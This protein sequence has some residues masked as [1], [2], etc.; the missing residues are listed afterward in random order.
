[1]LSPNTLLNKA[2][3]R[4]DGLHLGGATWNVYAA[5]DQTEGASVLV[6]EHQ[7]EPMAFPEHEGLLKTAD[8]FLMNGRRYDVTEP[9][10]PGPAKE[11][12]VG[13]TWDEF[14]V[15]L[16]A[17]NTIAA[18]GRNRCV[19]CPKT[20]VKASG[21]RKLLAVERA[22]T[23]ADMDA[24]H[25]P[26]EGIW[27]DLDHISQ[28]AIYTAWDEKSIA[29]LDLPLNEASDI[30]SVAAL[31][32][33]AITGTTPPSAFER[34]VVGM[35][36][37]DPLVA[38]QGLRPDLGDEGGSHLL[39]CLELLRLQRFQTFEDAIMNLPTLTFTSP[40]A[41][42]E[43]E[44][45]VL[46]LSHVVDEAPVHAPVPVIDV[47]GT[48]P[49][50]Q[51]S[52]IADVSSVASPP[53]SFEPSTVVVKEHEPPIFSHEAAAK[54]RSGMKF[55]IAGLIVAIAGGIGWGTY[56][57]AGSSTVVPPSSVSAQV[58]APVI[59]NEPAPAPTQIPNSETS[60]VPASTTSEIPA[61]PVQ[62]DAPA[63]ADAPHQRPQRAAKTA[64]KA[65]AA[66]DNKPKKKVTVDDLINDN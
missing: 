26:I 40:P 42:I 48:V 13:R 61:E 46:D 45:Y 33:Y 47:V 6:V 11:A 35:D 5:L 57:F 58:A 36:A 34:T 19:I 44:V 23:P 22:H 17:L 28:R 39:R 9:V 32:Y 60:V 25:I 41:A 29:D 59:H 27:G 1:M 8:S 14:S 10:D 51:I 18:A 15:V 56:Q 4:V 24:W 38:P 50:P 49:D 53:L 62:A 55:A 43:E 37:T 52:S 12:V 65:P 16:M 20:L 2:R 21:G 64:A 31:F 66:P 54:G 7:T 30:F 63:R 3:Y